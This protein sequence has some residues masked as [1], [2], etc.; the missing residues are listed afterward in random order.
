MYFPADTAMQLYPGLRGT[1]RAGGGPTVSVIKASESRG[2]VRPTA[3]YD[4]ARICHLWPSIPHTE[5]G[6]GE[7]YFCAILDLIPVMQNEPQYTPQV[8]SESPG[9]ML[10][11]H[12]R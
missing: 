2:K 3:T 10:S 1:Q 8:R 9:Y 4:L 7:V 6:G 5:E 12:D 11:M